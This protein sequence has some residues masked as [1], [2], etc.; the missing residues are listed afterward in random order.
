[1]NKVHEREQLQRQLEDVKRIIEESKAKEC[2]LVEQI[3][4]LNVEI[5]TDSTL[6]LVHDVTPQNSL[7]VCLN[8]NVR[9]TPIMDEY[10]E[11]D[12][13]YLVF[14]RQYR[15][16]RN[17]Y[18]IMKVDLVVMRCQKKVDC[19]RSGL[20]MT[21]LKKDSGN[22]LRETRLDN[23][24]KRSRLIPLYKEL[25]CISKDKLVPGILIPFQKPCFLGGQ[26]FADQRGFGSEYNGDFLVHQGREY[27][28]TTKFLII[29]IKVS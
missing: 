10:D 11:S 22:L 8:E 7:Y 17:D 23:A 29:G 15:L 4:Q 3:H 9:T 18:T 2:R 5:E 27:G 25:L 24:P 20:T 6:A 28:E 26:T 12:K 1:M 16:Y 14:G 13:L 19:H 21:D